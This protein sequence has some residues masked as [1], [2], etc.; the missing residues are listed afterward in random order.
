MQP[1][2]EPDL[3]HSRHSRPMRSAQR[4]SCRH[5]RGIQAAMAARSSRSAITSTKDRKADRSS[6]DCCQAWPKAGD[7][8]ALKGNHDAMM[9]DGAAQPYEDGFLAREGRRCRAGVLWRRSR[10]HSAKP[11]RMARRTATDARRR[12]T[13][14]TFTPA[15]IPRFRWISRAKRRCCGSAIRR[16]SPAASADFTSFT[17][18]IILPRARY[19]I[20]GRT[21]LD[22][23]AWRTGR[24]V[25]GVFD[26]DRP[27]GPVDFMVIRGSPAVR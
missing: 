19:C 9:A 14:S 2:N 4:G 16:G 25:I 27:G 11:L 24:L 23:L 17:V 7:L 3:R 6:N 20:E 21:N 10:R 12:I 26:D 5:Q 13:G 1:P 22:T 15:S 18:M 8:L